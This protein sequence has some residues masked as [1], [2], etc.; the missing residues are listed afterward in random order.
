LGEEGE[1]NLLENLAGLRAEE[2]AVLTLLQQR[3]SRR[4]SLVRRHFKAALR[5][6]IEKERA[7]QPA[8]APSA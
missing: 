3:P 6:S 8:P 1:E 5:K 4:E 2:M 7:V